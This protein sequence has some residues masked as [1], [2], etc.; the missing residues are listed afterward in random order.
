M[1]EERTY[2]V[3]LLARVEGEGRFWLKTAGD[4]V[5]DARLSIF[6]A[7]RLF[8]AML[9]GRAID[10]VP[11]IVA[12]ICGICPIAYQ[13]SAVGALE[14]ALGHRA[15]TA[16]RDL[17]RLMYC[18]EW[19]ESH[20]LHVFLLHA[21]D[22][23]GYPSAV[24]MAA[25]HRALVEQG[26]AIK[27]AGNRIIELLGGRAIHPV[28]VRVGGFT[29]VPDR[30]ELLTLR[31]ELVA[32]LEAAEQA[33]AWAA[34]LPFPA[35]TLDYV[36]VALRDDR[37]AYP[38]EGGD[39]LVV[40]GR[41]PVP[42]GAFEAVFVE[43]QVEHSNALQC[44]LADGTPYL[45]GPMARLRWFAD[46]L[47][48]RAAA[49]L[50]RCGLALPVRNPYQSIV[51]RAIELVH[52]FAAALE[53]IDGYDARAEPAYV[54]AP[55]GR[56]PAG[57]G[58]GCTEAPRGICWHRYEVDAEGL[59]ADARIIPPTSQNQARIEADLVG[60]A[61]QLVA[62]EHGAATR[63][64]EQLIRSYDPCISCATHFLRLDI[65]RAEEPAP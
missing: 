15:P 39:A 52:A 65:E 24:E 36:Y 63:R 42:L 28:S 29:R 43:S 25:D 34:S 55:A 3:D 38:L 8:E 4:A 40:D 26:L 22:F 19:I 5:L 49:A 37:G 48:P 61:P 46:R 6:E 1:T 60:L 54:E 45:T 30:R 62:M 2:K 7:P 57:V 53:V 47:H 59:I 31:P 23:L 12:R 14:E 51:V 35:L 18:G 44:R 16:I 64:C 13:M 9:R 10:E 17:R 20:A 21:P 32:G 56:S 33:V 11:D 41:E 50:E 27:K 58:I